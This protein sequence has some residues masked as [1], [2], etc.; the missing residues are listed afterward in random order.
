MFLFEPLRFRH[1]S[2][3]FL[4]SKFVSQ[5]SHGHSVV[6][7]QSA[8]SFKIFTFFNDKHENLIMTKATRNLIS[9]IRFFMFLIR[10]QS[11]RITLSSRGQ[12]F[13]NRCCSRRP[14]DRVSSIIILSD[15]T[16]LADVRSHVTFLGNIP[17]PIHT[18]QLKLYMLVV[19]TFKNELKLSSFYL[20]FFL[21]QELEGSTFDQNSQLK[22]SY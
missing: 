14:C 6:E 13:S 17:I 3:S 4:L 12:T 2:P 7:I 21:L 5:I 22:S 9:E 11:L 20:H 8:H 1:P 18:I 19:R 16:S 15:S 10:Q